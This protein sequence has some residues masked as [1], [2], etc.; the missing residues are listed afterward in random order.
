[1]F[2]QIRESGEQDTYASEP[3]DGPGSPPEEVALL[4]LVGVGIVPE[5]SNDVNFDRH[6]CASLCRVGNNE[7]QPW[8]HARDAAKERKLL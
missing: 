6:P 2:E 5:K 8:R 3:E 4:G 1:M 7:L